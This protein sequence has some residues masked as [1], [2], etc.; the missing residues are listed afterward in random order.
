MVDERDAGPGSRFAPGVIVRRVELSTADGVRL[1]AEVALPEVDGGPRSAFVLCHPHP[2]YGG[3]MHTPVPAALFAALPARGHACLRF[4]FRGVG[5]SGG[6]HS[7]GRDEPLDVVAALDA[8]DAPDAGGP[9]GA[10]LPVGTPLH[11]QGWSFGALMALAVTDARVRSWFAVAP[12]LGTPLAAGLDLDA[13]AVDE[14]AKLVA[15]G[16]HDQACDPTRLVSLVGT[17]RNARTVVVEGTDHF[18]AGH[19]GVLVE[20]AADHAD[21][22]ERPGAR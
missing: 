17:W 14:R 12:P 22:Q 4:N 13:V 19:T 3:S 6:T 15:V 8:L 5:G 1:E 9:L 11:L 16:R 21:Q 20:L 7:G 18:F 2:S 10:A